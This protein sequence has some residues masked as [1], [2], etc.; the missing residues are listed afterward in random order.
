MRTLTTTS[1]PP[2]HIRREITRA[3]RGTR[4]VRD[5]HAPLLDAKAA[6]RMLGVPLTWLLAQA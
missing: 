1:S 2:R 5:E 4:R 6:G 3:L